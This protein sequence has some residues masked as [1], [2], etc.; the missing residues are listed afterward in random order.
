MQCIIQWQYSSTGTVNIYV[1]YLYTFSK[2]QSIYPGTYRRISPSTIYLRTI[3][4]YLS[5]YLRS[6]V[7]ICYIIAG[8]H[9]LL[10]SH[11]AV[12]MQKIQIFKHS[13][14]C[15]SW[16][17]LDQIWSQV[18]SVGSLLLQ[19]SSIEGEPFR[20][21]CRQLDLLSGRESGSIKFLPLGA[22]TASIS[23]TQCWTPVESPFKV[24][25]AS[26]DHL[27]SSEGENIPASHR[28]ETILIAITFRGPTIDPWWRET[29]RG[30]RK[31]N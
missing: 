26:S 5:I 24:S 19:S 7:C 13:K 8:L 29:E 27:V 18:K 3:Y 22:P 4:S 2:C 9:F 17:W 30:G 31:G 28:G 12:W 11:K 20:F 1:L 15:S 10:S 21:F 14:L 6:Y 25:P 16:L 23:P